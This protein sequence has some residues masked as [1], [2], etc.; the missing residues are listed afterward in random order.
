MDAPEIKTEAELVAALSARKR[1][2]EYE[3][4]G[5]DEYAT[6]VV[7]EA[8]QYSLLV[9]YVDA[10]VADRWIESHGDRQ[11]TP[12]YGPYCSTWNIPEHSGFRED[13]IE[14]GEAFV[15]GDT[16]QWHDGV[17]DRTSAKPKFIGAWEVVGCVVRDEGEWV[18]VE[19]LECDVWNGEVKNGPAI[20]C[21][22]KR[23][24]RTIGRSGNRLPREGEP[25]EQAE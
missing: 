24:R 12:F 8:R 18:W 13:W 3:V 23:A 21:V 15:K 6:Y 17:F 9:A 1:Y 19:V 22:I 11:G 5:A 25:I 16:V 20:G 10:D 2:L 14:C 4:E 7:R